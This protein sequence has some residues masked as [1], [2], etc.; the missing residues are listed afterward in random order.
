M[1]LTPPNIDDMRDIKIYLERLYAWLAVV[2]SRL[3]DFESRISE[4]E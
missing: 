1:D 2:E 4:L 3:D